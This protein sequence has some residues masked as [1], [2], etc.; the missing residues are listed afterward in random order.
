MGWLELA[1]AT[2]RTGEPKIGPGAG[3]L[4]VTWD[5]ATPVSKQPLNSTVTI[6]LCTKGGFLLLFGA[7]RAGGKLPDWSLRSRQ[8]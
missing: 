3:E 7:S 4:T 2:T 6:L 1:D 8:H 5:E